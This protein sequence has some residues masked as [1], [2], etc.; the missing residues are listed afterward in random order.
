MT[1]S[2]FGKIQI[3]TGNGKGKTT[4]S[5]GLAIRAAGRGKKT[6][7]VYFDKGGQNYG[8][9]KILD[10]LAGQ[11]NYYVT[12][13]QRFNPKT[14]KFIFGVTTIDKQEA[15]RALSIVAKLYK[16]KRLDLLILD[17]I[18]NAI[19]LDMINVAKVLKLLRQKPKH[20]ELVLTGR[21]A[22]P[23]IIKMADLVTEMKLVKH[24]FYQGLPARKGIEF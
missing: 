18:N 6:A 17:E 22:H 14:K 7:I 20:L 10:R 1:V 21:A 15:E 11:I 5:L 24:Y 3:Y 23:K 12:G 8:E 4:A 19:N 16:K 2:D 13:R 9:R